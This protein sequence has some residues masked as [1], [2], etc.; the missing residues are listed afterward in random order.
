MTHIPN[1][2]V[3]FNIIMAN[4]RI[5]PPSKD[6]D[7]IGRFM[8]NNGC[9]KKHPNHRQSPGVCSLCLRHKLSQLSSASMR[10]TTL[11]SSCRSSSTSSSLSSYCSS[12]SSSCASPTLPFPFHKDSKSGSNSVSI[13]LLSAKHGGVLKTGSMSVL[14]TRRRT[15]GGGG[16]GDGDDRNKKKTGFW[17]KLL[18]PKTK[19]KRMDEIKGTKLVHS[20]SLIETR[21]I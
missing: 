1:D 15:K 5:R 2:N 19:S 17:S 12:S 18:H 6:K 9:C 21:H 8:P 13:F 4:L 16:D 14:A 3:A 10:K 20:R 7:I 11:I